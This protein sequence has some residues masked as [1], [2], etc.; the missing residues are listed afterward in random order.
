MLP[1]KLKKY[2]IDGNKT[3]VYNQIYEALNLSPKLKFK[4]KS[5]GLQLYSKEQ[6]YI[7]IF[8]YYIFSVFIKLIDEKT[9]TRVV[10]T[11]NTHWYYS[12]IL[13]SLY[14]FSFLSLL[15]LFSYYFFPTENMFNNNGEL[16]LILVFIII[17]FLTLRRRFYINKGF[18]VIDDLI[19]EIQD[20]TNKKGDA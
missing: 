3:A 8:Q 4:E 19:E 1:P 12:L 5:Y 17:I 20:N 7:N 6:M 18:Q 10:V 16:S 15:F 11:I 2:Y 9:R 13:C 14:F